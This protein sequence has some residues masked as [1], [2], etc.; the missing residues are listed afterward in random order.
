MFKCATNDKYTKKV[1][2]NEHID[3]NIEH[4]QVFVEN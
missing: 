2:D 3:V 1:Y 4:F